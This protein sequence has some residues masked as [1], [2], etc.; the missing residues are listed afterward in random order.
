MT[1]L[2]Q[3]DNLLAGGI[4]PTTHT[5]KR[6]R[7]YNLTKCTTLPYALLTAEDEAVFTLCK[8]CCIFFRN[9]SVCQLKNKVKNLF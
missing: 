7:S 1:F 8:C 3:S 6:S 2:I 9:L 4:A 5:F